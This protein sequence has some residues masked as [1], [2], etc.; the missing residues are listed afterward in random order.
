LKS[1][2]P[3]GKIISVIYAQA[4]SLAGHDINQK[5]CNELLSELFGDAILDRC[6]EGDDEFDF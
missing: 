6:H 5:Q 1:V 2:S 4:I 3:C